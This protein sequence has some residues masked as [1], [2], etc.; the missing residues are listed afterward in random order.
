MWRPYRAASRVIK[1]TVT[2]QYNISS[3][4]MIHW[5]QCKISSKLM[6]NQLWNHAHKWSNLKSYFL[7]KFWKSFKGMHH[8]CYW[9]LLS[10]IYLVRLLLSMFSIELFGLHCWVANSDNVLHKLNPIGIGPRL[11]PIYPTHSFRNFLTHDKLF[12][13]CTTVPT[14]N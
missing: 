6:L 4:S 8:S 5:K 12:L 9:H 10:S 11:C 13:H 7:L 14:G 3:K 2:N 1:Y